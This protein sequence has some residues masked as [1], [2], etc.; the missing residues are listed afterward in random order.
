MVG[1]LKL[2]S[3][4]TA[5]K[6][7]AGLVW[8][9]LLLT[10]ICLTFHTVSAD[11][12]GAVAHAGSPAESAGAILPT[13]FGMHVHMRPMR[14]QPWPSAPIGS[15]RFADTVVG[16]DRMNPADG[17]YDWRLFDREMAELKSHNIADVLFTFHSTP[18]WASSGP[19]H[20]CAHGRLADLPEGNSINSQL[21][22]CDPPNDLKPDGSGSDQHWID[23]LTA[24][25]THNKESRTERVKYW[26]VWNEP[27]NDFFWSGTDAQ[28]VRMA[29]DA[30]TTIKRIDPDALIL[31]PS[32]GT[33]P[34]LGMKWMDSYLAAGGGQYADVIAFHG[35]L[36]TTSAMDLVSRVA[37]FRQMLASHGQDT[38]PLWDTEASWGNAENL[39]FNEEQQAA[40]LA[41]FYL[42]HWSIG[43]PRLY[44]FGW[45]DGN[46]GTL[47]IPDSENPSG[48]G[49]LTRA[50]RAYIE[51][52]KWIVGAR[53]T[54]P[55]AEEGGIW[56]CELQTSDGHEGQVVWTA[57]GDKRYS[58][59]SSL[60]R[61]HDLDGNVSSIAGNIR[62]H[63][64]PV[65]LEAQ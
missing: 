9:C 11:H 1:V 49:T 18:T 33:N 39:G 5:M 7:T 31:S 59:K 2:P 4:E 47:W 32:P 14:P 30:Y 16:W 48:P 53:L 26:E 57:G 29:R 6:K 12:S 37:N 65:L 27:H 34:R 50:G 23:F 58:P 24:L 10:A 42:L 45:N 8:W 60:T 64:T 21:G 44:W 54:R 15:F 38:K 3:A 25:A 13:L 55:C 17:R 40:F 51:V 46:V 35:Y 43:I 63:E 28:M 62:V 41:Q 61:A 36:Q 20:R 52:Y 19:Y 22:S 56:T